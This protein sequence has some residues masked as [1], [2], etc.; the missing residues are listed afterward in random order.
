M[1][2]NKILANLNAVAFVLLMG[3]DFGIP[4]YQMRATLVAAFGAIYFQLADKKSQ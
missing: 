4:R 2:V 1:N 3:I